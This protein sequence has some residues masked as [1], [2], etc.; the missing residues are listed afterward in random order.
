M[1]IL[2]S[3]QLSEQGVDILRRAPGFEV[4]V[5]TGLSPDELKAI[6]PEYDGLVVRSA[7]KVT[8]E[9]LAA[10]T[11]LK[12]VG[13]AG[14]GVDNIDVP[15]A[16]R[17]G[18]VVMN[19]PGG[20]TITVAEL[21][22]SMMLA[23][24]R[25]LP[26]ATQSTKGGKWEK[27]RF[28]GRELNGKTL[29]LV[30]AGNIGGTVA[31]RCIAFGMKV[32]AYDPFL[33]ADAAGRLGVEL[34][35][36]DEITENSDV[37]SLHIPLTSETKNLFD[38]KR[39]AR[40]KQGAYLI[41]CARGGL[42]DEAALAEALRSGH[43]GGAAF[44]VFEKEPPAA[45]N[46]LFSCDNFICTPHI[47][48]STEEAQSNVALAIADQLVDYLN[49]G[50]IRNAVN[51]PAV[52]PEI[53]EAVAPQLSLAEKLGSLAGQLRPPSVAEVTVEVVGDDIPAAA[54]EAVTTA[55]LKGLLASQVESGINEVNAP[56]I[57][58]ER[59]IRVTQKRASTARDYA[60][61][62]TVRISGPQGDRS[63]AGSF[64]GRN[65]RIVQ[66][67]RFSIDAAAEGHMLAINNVDKPGVIGSIGATLGEQGV[68]IAQ[69]YL[70]RTEVG[71]DAF[72][73]ITVDA[74]PST[75]VLN[76]LRALPFVKDVT[77]IEL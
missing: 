37:I 25:H 31:S 65:P 48:A 23:L 46:P 11:K 19:T 51:V 29:G 66:I 7:T 52:S 45:D 2:V 26:T 61:L 16:T 6:I 34:A 32:L 74:E 58:K 17:R 67:D 22:V 69:L 70:G 40:M 18:V 5:K 62:L 44:D 36:L 56:L 39:L 14:S 71:G 77:P 73:L 21:T 60:S 64:F 30:G 33:T 49:T 43:L 63:V 55:V 24:A 72:A 35:T 76:K 13:R 53:L 20:N 15:E 28:E 47:G 57:A 27:K 75:E 10:A 12:A 59:G 54:M 8:A 42:V 3:D 41:N 38:A 1:R 4:D 9:V 50:N 68:N